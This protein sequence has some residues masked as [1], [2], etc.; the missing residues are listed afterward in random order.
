M[1]LTQALTKTLTITVLACLLQA[2]SSGDK[3]AEQSGAIPTGQLH[4]LD[5]AKGT[6]K[7]ME[8]AEQERRKKME[9]QGI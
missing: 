2:C 6:Q 5:K 4:A 7:M 3:D 1:N 9:E 8:D